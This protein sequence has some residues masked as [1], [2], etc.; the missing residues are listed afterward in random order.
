[1]ANLDASADEF[2]RKDALLLVAASFN[3]IIEFRL[4]RPSQHVVRLTD[5]AA[6]GVASVAAAAI[7]AATD[8]REGTSHQGNHKGS[9]QFHGSILA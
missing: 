4:T 7:V 8:Y 1:M 5:R 2:R 9:A 6:A 3:A